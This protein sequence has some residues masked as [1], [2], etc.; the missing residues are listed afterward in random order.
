MKYKYL[1]LVVLGIIGVI[2][3]L[4]ITTTL[5]RNTTTTT[6]TIIATGSTLI[7]SYVSSSVVASELPYVLVLAMVFAGSLTLAIINGI[8]YLEFEK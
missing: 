2:S 5:P 6:E 8:G 7:T 1:C 3:S 4:S